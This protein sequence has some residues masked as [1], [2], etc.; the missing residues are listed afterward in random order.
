MRILVTG[1]A[2]YIGI[3]TCLE[4]LNH[5]HQVVVIDNLINSNRESISRV[6]QITKKKIFT[7]IMDIRDEK[8]L[9]EVFENH[10]ID[11]VIHFAGLKAV[12]ESV[13]KPIL[14]YDNNISGTITL[15]RVMDKYGVYNLVFSSSATVYGGLNSSPL[16]EEMTMNTTNP[17]GTTKMLIE[18]MLSD[19]QK[20]NDKWSVI[21]LRYFNPIGAHQSGLIGEDPNGIPANLV[22][23]IAQTAIGKRDKLMVFGDDYDTADGTGVRD[24]IHVVDL[25]RG[26][27]CAID[28]VFGHSGYEA[29]NLGTGRG[30]S[31]LEVIKTFSEIS[32]CPIPYEIVER[33]KGDI[34]ECYADVEKAKQLLDFSAERG[35]EEMCRDTWRWQSMNPKGYN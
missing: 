4:L 23:Y 14:Y 1:G 10:Q 29:I 9:E 20:T 15:L 8:R 32:G 6:E 34:G 31:V 24:Y 12:G 30:Y 17:Y 33:R 21:A 3:H 26:H 35:I 16:T 11:G 5:G 19:L 13:E 28:Y 22:P 25:A 7:Y 2:G 18:M 27:V